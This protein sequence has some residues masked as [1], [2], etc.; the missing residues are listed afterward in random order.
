MRA[1]PGVRAARE[2]KPSDAIPLH[3]HATHEK[4]AKRGTIGIVGM[5]AIRAGI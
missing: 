5:V 3:A 1:C 4:R 2:Q